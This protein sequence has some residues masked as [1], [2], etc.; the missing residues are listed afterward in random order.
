M[1][2]TDESKKSSPWW[3]R[4]WVWVISIAVALAAFLGWYG[5][6]RNQGKVFICDVA[7]VVQLADLLPFCAEPEANGS[8][9][10]PL[11]N[12]TIIPVPDISDPLRAIRILR[13][14]T[15]S[16]QSWIFDITLENASNAQLVLNMF[17]LRWQ[18]FRG[19][20]SSIAQAAVI[21]PTVAHAIE[22][23]IDPADLTEHRI[24]QPITPTIVLPAGSPEEPSIHVFRLELLYALEGERDYH[25]TSDWNIVYSL[26][27]TT[28][29]GQVI[30]IFEGA[31]WRGID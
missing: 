24:S 12:V 9:I 16:E 1:S 30:P 19:A 23:K 11:E 14:E 20:L 28:T 15:A 10:P 13:A 25:S 5:D 27:L 6:V 29:V 17:E 2:K 26:N 8:R 18:Y 4:A 31:L 3:S 22:M 21:A 7:A